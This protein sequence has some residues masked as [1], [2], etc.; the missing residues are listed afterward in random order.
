MDESISGRVFGRPRLAHVAVGLLVSAGAIW[1][2]FSSVNLEIVLQL[3]SAAALPP[4]LLLLATL[5]AQ[6]VI[7]AIRWSLLLPRRHGRRVPARRTL[8]PM[9]V[10]YLG[11]ALLPARLGEPARALLVARRESLP[12]AAAFG[13]VVLERIID[14]T[15]LALL[16]LPAAWLLG[17]PGWILDAALV[18]AVISGLLLLVLAFTGLGG[19][20]RLGDRIAN[21]L[22]SNLVGTAA[23]RLAGLLAEFSSGAEASDRRPIVVVAALLSLG[24]WLLDAGMFWL[25]SASLGAPVEP[26]QAVVIAAVAVLGTAVPSAPGY[27]GTYELAATA[28]AVAL[29]IP[30]EQALAVAIL[31]HS[32]TL[33]PM[34]VAGAVALV[35]IQREGLSGSRMTG[36][37][38]CSGEGDASSTVRAAT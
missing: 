15:T 31:V 18:A 2:V 3:L 7:R 8:A 21:R 6:T 29:G 30:A 1:L 27:V 35:A 20:V 23:S 17:A 38:D 24:A 9:L 37:H 5:A 4:L 36:D 14:T 28:A 10:G 25:A 34:A 22:R 13:S 33:I 32:L 16:L 11:N 26:V 12:A 19:L